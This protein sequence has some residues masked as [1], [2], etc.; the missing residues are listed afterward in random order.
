MSRA[1]E[2]L[3]VIQGMEVVEEDPETQTQ[4]DLNQAS[5]YTYQD[6]G[7]KDAQGD[8]KKKSGT[9]ASGTKA[10]LASAKGAGGTSNVSRDGGKPT[11]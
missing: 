2:I 10:T 9:K 11:A 3:D 5:G 4:H 7:Q 1:K 6:R 8:T